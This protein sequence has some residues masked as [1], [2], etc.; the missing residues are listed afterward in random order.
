[1]PDIPDGPS[2]F[3]SRGEGGVCADGLGTY[4]EALRGAQ[5]RFTTALGAV[6]AVLLL[7]ALEETVHARR[8]AEK[9]AG[10]WK[11]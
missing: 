6:A 9:F 1:V 11:H 8:R 7:V 5:E 10:L 2:L 3:L 4:K